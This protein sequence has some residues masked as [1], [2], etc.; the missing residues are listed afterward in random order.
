MPLFGTH[1]VNA[2]TLSPDDIQARLE[3]LQKEHVK[4]ENNKQNYDTIDDEIFQLHDQKER[5]E[6]DSHHHEEVMDRINELQEFIVGQETD[7]TEFG[8][9]LVKKLIEKITVFA[10]YFIVE[11]K[12]GTTIDKEA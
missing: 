9:T 7:I 6:P 5:S 10:D 3:E 4:K 8:G 1:Q 11:F 12:S 2:G